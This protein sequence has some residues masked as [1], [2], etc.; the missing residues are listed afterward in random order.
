[1]HTAHMWE[2][3][4]TLSDCVRQGTRTLCR[5][6][7]AWPTRALPAGDPVGALPASVAETLP[8]PADSAPAALGAVDVVLPI[9]HGPFGEDGTVQGL[10]ELAEDFIVYLV[11]RAL[12]RCGEQLKRLERD[13]KKLE[14]ITKPFPRIT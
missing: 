11:G 2:N 9:L 6:A 8:I 3:W 4:S 5:D 10:C 7:V 14:I 12:E 13:P 1:M